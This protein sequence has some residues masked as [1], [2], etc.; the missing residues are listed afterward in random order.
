MSKLIDLSGQQFG[1]LTAICRND[2]DKRGRSMWLCICDCGN[3]KIIRIDHLRNGSIRSCGCLQKE[4]ATK[5]GYYKKNKT[6]RTYRIWRHVISRC[7]RQNNQRWEYYGGRGIKVCKRWMKFEN[8]LEDMEEAPNGLQLD[9]INNNGGYCKSNCR[10]ATPKQN[11]RN[12][13]DNRLITYKNK[14]QCLSAWSEE[15]GIRSG[16][17]WDRLFRYGWSVEQALTM[18]IYKRRK[19]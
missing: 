13:R 9:R 19:N 4:K 18:P 15:L 14:T 10:W 6:I 16:L 17:I 8:F 1:R 5:H 7:T 2:N 3:E 12:R 11:S